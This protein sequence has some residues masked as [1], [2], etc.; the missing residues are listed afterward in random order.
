M[1]IGPDLE[2]RPGDAAYLCGGWEV[3]NSDET[4][5]SLTLMHHD[6]SQNGPPVRGRSKIARMGGGVSPMT[7]YELTHALPKG[8]P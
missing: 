8:N 6:V 2:P 7:E 4:R 1:T 3:A 5:T